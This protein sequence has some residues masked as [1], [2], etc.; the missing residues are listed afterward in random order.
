MSVNIL[1][2]FIVLLLICNLIKRKFRIGNIC[3][4]DKGFLNKNCTDFLKGFTIL[5]IAIAHICQYDVSLKQNLI[6][7]SVT[8]RLLFSWGAVGVSI[9]FLLSGYGCY[10]SVSGKRHHLIWLLKHVIKMLI[11]FM[12]AFV[13]V[14]GL[15]TI[16]LGVK[17]DHKDLLISFF[18]LRFPGASVWY[19]KI[20]ILF[21]IF[22]VLSIYISKKLTS[23]YVMIMSLSYSLIA[24][25][26]IG[27]PDYWWKTSLCFSVGCFIAQYRHLVLKYISKSIIFFLIPIFGCVA[28][29]CVL[30]DSQYRI[31]VQ[32]LGYVLISFC[33]TM[34]W[35]KLYNVGG[36]LL[37][38]I[39]CY[40]LDIYLIHIG[41]VEFVYNIGL[42]ENIETLIFLVLS[43]FVS[44]LCYCFSDFIYRNLF[45]LKTISNSDERF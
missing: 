39:G 21:Y 24:V 16:F 20:Q 25:Y 7:G 38:K 4:S 9:F 32:L 35:N 43:C 3:L 26:F 28:Y 23:I 22:L 1:L 10:I 36:G 8:Y 37:Q 6:G 15:S 41:Y 12:V 13:F 5:M 2:A 27:L 34:I 40:S 11:H 30:F 18:E 45:I 29:I 19:F 44:I 14:T 17:Y 31:I 33:I 42:N